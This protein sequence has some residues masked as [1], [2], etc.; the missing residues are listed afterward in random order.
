[1]NI[2]REVNV[3]KCAGAISPGLAI[4]VKDLP[5]LKR[6]AGTFPNVMDGLYGVEGLVLEAKIANEIFEVVEDDFEEPLELSAT[7]YKE[8]VI[9]TGE[10]EE[11]I[12]DCVFSYSEVED[13]D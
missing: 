2:Q 8:T 6:F 4:R 12:V 5:R 3:V 10:N 7:F 9:V 1:M 13:A 11:A